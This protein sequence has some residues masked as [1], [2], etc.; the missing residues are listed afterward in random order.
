MFI[1]APVLSPLDSGQ[2]AKLKS[3]PGIR[4]NEV[5]PIAIASPEFSN[6]VFAMIGAAVLPNAT[7]FFG[8]DPDIAF[9][10]P[11]A[12][13]ELDFRQG[14]PQQAAALLK[15]GRHVIVTEELHQLK[16]LG[17]GDKISLKTP[18]HGD[19]EYTIAGVVWSPG[20]DVIVSMQDMGRQFDQRTAA[21]LFGTLDDAK[22][23]FGI[24]HVYIVA[25]NLDGSIKKEAL[26]DR[27]Q[28]RLGLVGMNVGDIRAMKFGIQQGFH[29]LLLLVSTVAIAAMGVASLGVTNTIMA[30]IRSRRWEL[31][32]L[33]SIGVTRSQL[34]RLVL[35]EAILLGLVGCALGLSAGALMSLNARGLGRLT[36]GYVP[37]ISI[38]WPIIWCGTAAVMLIAILASLWPAWNVSRAEP[39]SLL[40]AGRASA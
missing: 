34:L 28:E 8:I 38:P 20:I 26:I 3:T 21:S 17:V 13:M 33:R 36:V 16:G 30:S 23:D 25:A 11:H 35:A 22:E 40:Q 5:M 31:G 24:D 39:L 18:K 2:V 15:Q 37:P 6:P 32:V 4:Q 7:M 9:T 27:I 10:G 14:N 12:M 19:V 29:T 1:T